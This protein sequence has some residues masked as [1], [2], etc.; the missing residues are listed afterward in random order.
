[1]GCS[2]GGLGSEGGADEAV[3]LG[4]V[5]G[6]EDKGAAGWRGLAEALVGSGWTEPNSPSPWPSPR[7][8]GMAGDA[9]GGWVHS[10]EPAAEG[11]DFGSG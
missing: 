1:M 11:S 8:E 6:P 2:V 10:E 9:G 5:G 3:G 7:G 4:V